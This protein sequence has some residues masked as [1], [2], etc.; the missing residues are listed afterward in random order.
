MSFTLKIESD[1]ARKA[2]NIVAPWGRRQK[3]EN[4]ALSNSI[5]IWAQP[6]YQPPK[7]GYV[8]PGALDFKKVQSK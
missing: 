3:A 5:N 4:E 2:L 6:V 1:S 7:D 8:R